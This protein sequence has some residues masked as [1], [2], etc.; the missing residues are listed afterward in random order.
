VGL[1]S[2]KVEGVCGDCEGDLGGGL[3][4]LLEGCLRCLAVCFAM[5][6]AAS[7]PDDDVVVV[8]NLDDVDSFVCWD[9]FYGFEDAD[10][11]VSVRVLHLVHWVIKHFPDLGD[12]AGTA[13]DIVGLPKTSSAVLIWLGEPWMWGPMPIVVGFWVVEACST[14]GSRGLLHYR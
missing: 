12:G 5:L 2:Y 11:E 8:W 4:G 3:S 1:F 7:L 13:C 10:S 6:S 9:L 14:T